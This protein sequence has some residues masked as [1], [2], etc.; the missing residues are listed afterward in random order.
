LL[1]NRVSFVTFNYDV[2]LE[3][4]LRNGLKHI[5]MFDEKEVASFLGGSRIVH[6]Y[7]KIRDD[8]AAA[9]KIDWNSQNQD[10]KQLTQFGHYHTK[11]KVLLDVVYNASKG[12]RV[13]DPHDKGTDDAEIMMA[14]T[15]IANA[16]RVFILGCGFDEDNSGRLSLRETLHHTAELPSKRIAFTNYQDI[17]Q[18]NKRTSNL[19]YGNPRAF[20]P[21]GLAMQDRYEKSTRNTYDALAMDFDLAD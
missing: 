16:Q 7:G 17:N 4:A 21:G 10:L 6:I 5:Q 3:H 14:R 12:L 18:I 9:V 8:V 2:S 13:I 19:F 1:L 20:P 11:M 15:A